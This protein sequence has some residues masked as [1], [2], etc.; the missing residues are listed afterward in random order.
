MTI[1][2]RLGFLGEFLLGTC[3]KCVLGCLWMVCGIPK[4]LVLVLVM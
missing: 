1:C 3:L 4:L 2:I